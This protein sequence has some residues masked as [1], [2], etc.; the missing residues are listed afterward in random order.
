MK[1][2]IL[3]SNGNLGTQLLQVF[4]DRN[5]VL[6]LD[7]YNTDFFDLKKLKNKINSY[8]P[9]VVINAVA[10]NNVDKCETDAEVKVL[11]EHLNI[12]LPK[13]LAELCL[14]NNYLLISYSSDYVFGQENRDFPYSEW[15]IPNPVNYYG[16][17]KAKGEEHVIKLGLL[18]LKHYLIRTSKLFGPQGKSS[19]TKKSFFDIMIEVSKKQAEI[20]VVDEEISSFTYTPDLAKYT[21]YLISQNY[22]FGIYHLINKGQATWAQA[23]QALFKVLKIGITIIPVSGQ[24]F[25]RPAPRPKYSLLENTKMKPLPYWKQSL[26]NY[27]KKYYL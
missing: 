16:L 24:E 26:E 23:A 10:Y 14:E 13:F 17:T 1:V 25:P 4:N 21:N 12:L 7:S 15:D 18:G 27:L 19:F 3:G 8:L 5:Q 11:A 2:L 6:G 20:K 22:P 9:D